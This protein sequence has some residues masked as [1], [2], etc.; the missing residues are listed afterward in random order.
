MLDTQN[1]LIL[2]SKKGYPQSSLL[3]LEADTPSL[4]YNYSIPNDSLRNRIWHVLNKIY[5]NKIV[6]NIIY[7]FILSSPSAALIS[8]AFDDK[9]LLNIQGSLDFARLPIKRDEN[10]TL[11][12]FSADFYLLKSFA[13]LYGIIIRCVFKCQSTNN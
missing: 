5:K 8:C 12:I 2:K 3:N 1:C 9:I 10:K 6:I 13:S 7:I 11:T 4:S